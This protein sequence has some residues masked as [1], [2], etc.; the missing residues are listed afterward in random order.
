VLPHNDQADQYDA[1]YRR[2]RALYPALKGVAQQ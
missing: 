2:Y 1:I